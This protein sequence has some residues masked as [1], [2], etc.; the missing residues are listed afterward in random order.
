MFGDPDRRS[1]EAS[2]GETDSDASVASGS[3]SVDGPDESLPRA[4]VEAAGDGLF[5]LDGDLRFTLVNP[6]F[7]SLV[8]VDRNALHGAPFS[9]VAGEDP[10]AAAE[11]LYAA[12]E[13]G[14]RRVGTLQFSVP[15]EPNRVVVEVRC[16]F[17][18][19]AGGV[20]VGVARDV[21]ER[22]RRR[23][24]LELQR[25]RFAHLHRI[26]SLVWE[27]DQALVT[28]TTQEEIERELCGRLVNSDL[29][30]VAW[31]GAYDRRSDSLVP[32]EWAGVDETGLADLCLSAPSE[33]D[34]VATPCREAIETGETQVVRLEDAPG[35]AHLEDVELD[36]YS[37]W[38]VIPLVHADVVH[39]TLNLYVDRP[40]AFGVDERTGLS[41][42][43]KT[44]GRAIA[45]AKERKL[46]YADGV[47]ELEFLAR[48]REAFFVAASAGT[49][50]RFVLEGTVPVSDQ[51]MLTYVTVEGCSPDRVSDLVAE[52]D[53][54]RGVRVVDDRADG[55][56]MAAVVGAR[57]SI[58]KRVNDCGARVVRMVAEDG[59]ARVEAHVP[60]D[61]NVR[62]LVEGVRELFP[63]FDLVA[64]RETGRAGRVD[65]EPRWSLPDSLTDRQRAA[66]RSAYYAGYFD[67]PRS[68]T[69]EEVAA[70]MDIS[71][72]T[73]HK[74]L[75]KAERKLFDAFLD[76]YRD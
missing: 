58:I 61:E 46:L 63:E 13:R 50:C 8:D 16:S 2:A 7:A 4:I 49:D 35:P 47:L 71:G 55:Y 43:G 29:Y 41:E 10:V 9:A 27:V 5:A 59:E 36:P 54:V 15:A 14:D 6:S 67:W 70:S 22:V 11:D 24:D 48:D 66:V 12:L 32:R 76:P 17:A 30:D 23:H 25:D 3:P 73:F 1:D 33:T 75:R 28:A 20:L 53:D 21:T 57:S 37:A 60:P 38:A 18:R 74:H 52:T 26:S 51:S 19:A 42:L 44:V 39:G 62:A 34:E 64:R 40:H 45:A 68:S 69:A 56:L 65:R 31:V 72:A